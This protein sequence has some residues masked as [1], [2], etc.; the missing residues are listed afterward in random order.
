VCLDA[1]AGS[2]RSRPQGG[3]TRFVRVFLGVFLGGLAVGGLFILLVDPYGVVPFSLPIERPLVEGNQRLA[4]PRLI[5]S[6]RFDALIIGSSTARSL[7]PEQLNGP[8][9]VRFANLAI[10]GGRA[11]EQM[12]LLDYYL[13]TVGAPKVLIVNLDFFWCDPD[14]ERKGFFHTDFPYWIYDDN[15]WNDYAHLFNTNTLEIA[16]RIVGAH[17]GLY[18]GQYR[19][20]GF[21]LFTPPDAQY[22]LEHARK[23]ITGPPADGL[24]SITASGEG[25]DGLKFPALDLLAPVLARI[26]SSSLKILLFL[27]MHA[28]IQ[29]KPGTLQTSIVAACK[30][31][32]AS[33]ATAHGAK[34]IDWLIESPITTDDSNYWDPMHFRIAVA[35]QIERGLIDAM[36][37]SQ[38]PSDGS[39]LL[40][41]R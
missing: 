25:P 28:A 3:W 10:A 31:R 2:A 30:A 37:R 8:F 39:Y 19:A 33:L 9:G 4:Y 12:A 38:E 11:G 16:G 18:R 20:D 5:R 7:D 23:Q 21:A 27:P 32:V 40:P 14:A 6:R 15:P 24:P 22:N 1:S 13:R 29:G 36:V 34:V 35:R 26:P 41:V 17:L